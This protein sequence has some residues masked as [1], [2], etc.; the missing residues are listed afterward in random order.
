MF[1]LSLLFIVLLLAISSVL[2]V[3]VEKDQSLASHKWG[4]SYSSKS[5]KKHFSK[6]NIVTDFIKT[7]NWTFAIS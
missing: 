4:Q 1:N 2:W 5:K 6:G 7:L 3:I